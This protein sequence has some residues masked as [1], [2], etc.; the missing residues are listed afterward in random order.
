MYP[1]ILLANIGP[2]LVTNIGVMLSKHKL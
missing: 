2:T 1:P